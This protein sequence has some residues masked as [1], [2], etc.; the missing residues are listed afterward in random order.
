MSLFR[1][2]KPSDE[3][4]PDAQAEELL[5]KAFEA[6]L[7]Y[8]DQPLSPDL[9]KPLR[10]FVD[11]L[12]DEAAISSDSGAIWTRDD[13]GSLMAS[14]GMAGYALR[15][16][17]E[18]MG[19]SETPVRVM[20]IGL[21]E[22]A[23][24]SPNAPLSDLIFHAC[25]G[26]AMPTHPDPWFGISKG[27]PGGLGSSARQALGGQTA[28]AMKSMLTDRKGVAPP[29]WVSQDLLE[30]CWRFGYS[31]RCAEVSLAPGQVLARPA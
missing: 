8:Y 29:A 3:P 5:E 21:S 12:I 22:L 28:S 19:N 14:T 7:E 10:R 1:R 30:G 31:I 11:L 9:G 24:E 16:F 2:K 23:E 6:S 18:Q 4:I 17:E 26:W 13:V 20:Q 27:V 25:G 15:T